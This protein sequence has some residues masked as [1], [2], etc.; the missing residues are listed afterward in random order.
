VRLSAALL[1]RDEA[2]HLRRCLTSLQGIVDEVVVVDTGSADDSVAVAESFG[3]TVLHRP[4]DDDFSAARNLGLDHVTGDWVLYIDADEHLSPTTRQHV[5]HELADPGE[6]HVAYRIRLRANK[7]FTPYWEW[8]LWRN[9]PDLRFHGVIHEAITKAIL[10]V[11]ERDDLKIGHADLLLEHEGYE[12]DQIAKHHRNLPLL[13]RQVQNDPERTYLWDH[14][15][16]IHL[17][18]GETDEALEAWGHAVDLVRANGVR[19]AVDCLPFLDLITN[20]AELDRPDPDLVADADRLF[21]GNPFITWSAA[22]DA[23]ARGDHA[24]VERRITAFLE[25]DA[26]QM[27]RQSLSVNERVVGDWAHHARGMARFHLGDAAGAAADFAEAQRLAPDVAE[28][29]VKRR[30]AEARIAEER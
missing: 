5:E 25:V 20:L 30:L 6:Q 1:V 4:W 11:A 21:P 3:A 15:G 24:E 26:E 27:A 29:G 9:H 2:D 23:I 28:Y 17:A 10:E 18:L 16:R 7:G 22:M 19:E 13:R 14:I 8:R 12:G